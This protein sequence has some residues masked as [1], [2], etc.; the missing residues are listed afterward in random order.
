MP[1]E[2]EGG[3]SPEPRDPAGYSRDL[4]AAVN[5]LLADEGRR[6]AMGKAARKRA[7]EEFSWRHIAEL[8]LDL[9]REL[10]A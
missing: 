8:T 7:V 3:G 6:I 9:Y 10:L 2:P 5:A 4:A 1:F